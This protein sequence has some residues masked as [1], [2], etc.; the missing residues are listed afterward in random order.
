MGIAN[1]YTPDV[2][3]LTAPTIAHAAFRMADEIR[4]L[5]ARAKDI[6]ANQ[7]DSKRLSYRVK[8]VESLDKN[9]PVQIVGYD[10]V[11][12]IV[13]VAKA[14]IGTLALGVT[15]DVISQASYG[16]ITYSGVLEGIDTSAWAEG[17]I[18]YVG[19]KGTYTSIQPVSG[20]A[21]PLLYVI[22]QSSVNGAVFVNNVQAVF[23]SVGNRLMAAEV[24]IQGFN[25]AVDKISLGLVA[26][27]IKTVR[28]SVT[29]V[30]DGQTTITVPLSGF[31]VAEVYINGVHQDPF[32][33]A[34]SISNRTF[35]FAKALSAGDSVYFILGVGYDVESNSNVSYELYTA[36]AGQTQFELTYTPIMEETLLFINGV[37]QAQNSYQINLDTIVLS[38]GLAA[39]DTVEVM[40]IN[41]IQAGTQYQD[42]ITLSK[43]VVM[44]SMLI[45]NGYNAGS[46]GPLNFDPSAVVTVQDDA[47]WTIT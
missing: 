5:K 40:R 12:D 3:D 9:V 2:D 4:L 26:E 21:Q 18:L 27:D 47:I 29:A 13:L 42:I 17:T 33:G 34:Y 6:Y 10:P 46:I 43:R 28:Y 14:D 8:A 44:D 36:S 39:G 24:E 1:D 19:D 15:S 31:K 41:R 16:L 23:E 22:K 7:Q 20:Y 35:T 38:K 11:L 37:K 25:Q 45:P 30:I 32:A